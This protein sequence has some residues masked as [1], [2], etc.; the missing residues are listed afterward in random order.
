MELTNL[1]LEDVSPVRKRLQIEVAAGAVQAEIDRA[2]QRVGQS[3]QLRG[4]RPGKAPRSVLER[5]FGDQIR[6]EVLGHLV[7]ESLHQAIEQHRLAVVGT[8]DIDAETLNPGDPLRFSATVD[9]RPEVVVGDLSGLAAERPAVAV[10][11]AEVDRVLEG[12]RESVAQLAP[13]EDRAVVEAG[14]VVSVDLTS[15]LDGGEPAHREGVLLEAGS[16]S[17]PL[18]LERQIVGQHRGAR[19]SLEV[20]YPAD[21]PSPNLAGKTAKFEVEVKDLRT[22]VLPSLDDDFARDH[23]RAESLAQFRDRVRSDLEQ[24][25]ADRA[26]A[27]VREAV[28]D[29]L[30]A[31]HAFDVPPSL[32]ERRGDA[33]LSSLDVRLPEGPAGQEALERLRA[34]VR[35]RAERAVRADLLLDAIAAQEG[36]VVDEAAI[37]AEIDGVARR[38]A[39]SP[40]R[41]RAFYQRPEARA[42]L[43]ARMV[44][45]SALTHVLGLAKI[46]P[47]VAGKEVAHEN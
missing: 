23:G 27:H 4:F 42:A 43:R 44:R 28:I 46:V 33:M 1:R 32:V 7:E 47:V 15:R 37:D 12:L 40:E 36:I 39:Q 26:E 35:P 17:F 18:A 8:P 31:R 38:E 10:D 30:L 29:Q 45:E 24:R 21:Y 16:G 20:P 41:V 14:D 25:S 3:A 2:F 19:L 13:I 34:E 6:R 9:V 22:K 5:M 11:D